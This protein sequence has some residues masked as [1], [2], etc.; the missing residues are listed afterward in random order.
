MVRN[1]ID[2]LSGRG[3]AID[4]SIDCDHDAALLCVRDDGP[5]IPADLRHKIFEPGVSSK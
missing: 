4:L 2:A 3:G 5:G 1:A